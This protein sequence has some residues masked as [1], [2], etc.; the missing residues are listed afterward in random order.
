MP[1]FH[2]SLGPVQEFVNQARRTSDFWAGSFLL[3]WLSGVAMCAVRLQGGRI[4]FPHPPSEYLDWIS[5]KGEIDAALARVGAI[6]N[7]FSADVTDKFDGKLVTQ[8]VRE[9]WLALANHTLAE[10]KIELDAASR[11]VWQRQ[12][13]DGALWEMQWLITM[14]E[15]RQFNA[16]DQRKR[17]RSQLPPAEPGAKCT[18]MHG[19]QELSG[20]PYAQIE[21]F[22]AKLRK[23]N[24]DLSNA[25]GETER[26]CTPALVK[27]RF[28]RHFGNFKH[29]LASGM[30]V[31]GWH[32][33]ASVPSTH[34][35]AALPWLE[36]LLQNEKAPSRLQALVEQAEQCNIKHGER[37]SQ[38][39][40][41]QQASQ[42]NEIGHAITS[43]DAIA[44]FS[45]EI[46]NNPDLKTASAQAKQDLLQQL[47]SLTQ[48][49]GQPSKF[50]AL[51][52]MD[53]DSLGK[54]IES[55]AE[56]LARALQAFT[57]AVPAI[58][59]QQSGFLVYAGGD[60]VLALLPLDEALACAVQL[61]QCYLQ[62]FGEHA[63]DIA[64]P[65]ISAA[66]EFAHYK[67]PLTQMINDAHL[68]LTD[69]A[70]H[71]HGRDSLA[72][73]VWK[74]S[75]QH[76]TWGMPWHKA[77]CEETGQLH[78]LLLA[79]R[80]DADETLFSGGFFQRAQLCYQQLANL[81]D[82][83]V[84]REMLVYEYG[85]SLQAERHAAKKQDIE[86]LLAPLFAQS[87]LW[88]RELQ[89]DAAPR[90]S[91]YGAPQADAALLIC[92]LL[93]QKP[94]ANQRSPAFDQLA[95]EN[96]P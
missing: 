50:Y 90:I 12:I 19:W 25:I 36:K 38:L 84:M 20:A 22:W 70:K 77:L 63:P 73:R 85:H 24:P 74:G 27:R 48:T 23:R 13:V 11:T 75:G 83:A 35:L 1:T 96:Q 5:G 82:E 93:Q 59:Q 2:F 7:R 46:D 88:R 94:R 95:S 18:L 71:Q 64:Q 4:I 66:I 42:Q 86:A 45:D 14:G 80:L 79:K 8:A 10:D 30:Q 6:P 56:S 3:S 60:D 17:W 41:L 91:A 78:V 21:A 62:C 61:R 32:L 43:L 49:H 31:R 65:S 34:H 40:R 44:F 55:H 15:N 39:L 28:E 76:L 29:T 81:D 47:G 69:I 89:S 58:V 51:L 54:H 37:S 67:T 16:L 68:L 92:F 72:V 33:N 87:Q 26:L 53:G 52:L 9:S 57:T